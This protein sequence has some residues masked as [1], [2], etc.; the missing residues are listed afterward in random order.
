MNEDEIRATA[1]DPA[2]EGFSDEEA[3]SREEM[4]ALIEGR[5][6]TY[7]LLARLFR[8]E[9]DETCLAELRRAKLPVATGNA[10]AD[11]GYRRI[12]VF[13]SRTAD[14][15]TLAAARD[16]A[17][18]FVGQGRNASSAAYPYESVYTSEKRLLMQDAR[19]EVL[20]IYRSEGFDKSAGCH[21]TEDHVALELEFMQ[22][23]AGRAADAL[24][25]GDEDRAAAL[26]RVQANF[27]TDHL[28]VWTPGL[29]ADMRRYAA[30]DLY[31][32]LAAL[33]DGFLASDAAFLQGVLG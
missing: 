2:G 32:G 29:T 25:A 6:A 15:D 17:R 20:A 19:D 14:G 31:R 4:A 11:E 16:F 26:L 7:A 33:T 22:A 12:A 24:R 3:V 13:L 5:A 21:E 10:D 1:A 18:C 23:M 27:L 9:P 8:A 30:T 28:L